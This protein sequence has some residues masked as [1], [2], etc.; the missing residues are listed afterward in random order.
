MTFPDYVRTECG[1][2]NLNYGL[3]FLWLPNKF[4]IDNT[5]TVDHEVAIDH[6]FIFCEMSTKKADGDDNEQ[7]CK[8]KNVMSMVQYI[9]Q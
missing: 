9:A 8:G 1:K 3:P 7:F 5:G 2:G 4:I 6:N